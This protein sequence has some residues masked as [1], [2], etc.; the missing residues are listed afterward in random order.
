MGAI[1]RYIL[2]LARPLKGLGLRKSALVRWLLSIIKPR[3]VIISGRTLYVDRA[4]ETITRTLLTGD[5]E[6]LET[7][8]LTTLIR[9]GNTVLDVGANIGYY[10]TLFSQLV[11]K[12][13]RVI[14]FEPTPRT[15]RLLKKNLNVNG[16]RNVEAHQ[17]ALSDISASGTLHINLYNRGGNRIYESP[18]MP[19]QAVRVERYDK[20]IDP[21]VR[22]DVIK[23]DV[24]GAEM[25][26]LRGMEG[27]IARDRP[28]IIAEFVPYTLKK[29]GTSAEEMLDFLS[30][31]GYAFE[32][33]DEISGSTRPVSREELLARY[34]GEKFTNILCTHNHQV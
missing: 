34:S 24:E 33:I 9:E 5:Y 2:K 26:A 25:L 22:I 16:C 30:K 10:T 29:A 18:G 13:G 19:T 32:D 23:I 15:F 20:F 12:H 7:K 8:I 27:M 28:T 11:G 14:A 21:L 1:Q 6:P 4:D 3:K 17:V 31:Y